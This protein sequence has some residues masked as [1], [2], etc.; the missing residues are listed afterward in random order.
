MRLLVK[1]SN[2]RIEK[3]VSEGL[4]LKP[5]NMLNVDLE[6]LSTEDRD[7]LSRNIQFIAR[8]GYFIT[9]ILMNANSDYR[10]TGVFDSEKF[11]DVISKMK[12]LEEARSQYLNEEKE[13]E[14]L[15]QKIDAIL[16]AINDDL[17]KVRRYSFNYLYFE[18]DKTE[19]TDRQSREF[20][21]NRNKKD[22][23]IEM[24]Y[25]YVQSPA[26]AEKI[27]SVKK[28]FIALKEEAKRKADEEAKKTAAKAAFKERLFTWSLE[29]GSDLLKL[30]IKY[31]QNW[32]GLASVEWAQSLVPDF[33]DEVLDSKDEW[34]VKNATLEQL[35]EL[36]A[37]EAKYPDI[38]IYINRHKF[39]NYDE[40]ETNFCTYLCAAVSTLS[41]TIYLYKEIVDVSEEDD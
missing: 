3:A 19:K 40:Q 23:T 15:A 36:E 32:F 35:K 18:C 21:P 1:I 12:K 28:E 24:L 16:S 33:T 34:K 5:E 8:D 31:E 10:T 2:T 38:E 9:S 29:H 7:V 17:I 27:E 14:L 37:A 26:L 6:N 39:L 25:E 41:N 11:E 13:K 4:L 20:R 30:R 22:D